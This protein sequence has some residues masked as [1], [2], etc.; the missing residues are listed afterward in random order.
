M[1]GLLE[2]VL[3][4]ALEPFRGGPVCDAGGLDSGRVGG[5]LALDRLRHHPK[6]Q[7]LSGNGFETRCF[8]FDC[9]LCISATMSS[10]GRSAGHE[11]AADCAN[12]PALKISNISAYK[13][14]TWQL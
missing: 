2:L 3:S 9:V 11:D 1:G 8:L 5:V 13:T 6:M 12:I 7:M 14:F 4:A 10:T